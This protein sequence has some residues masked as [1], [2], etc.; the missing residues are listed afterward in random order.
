[1]LLLRACA[2]VSFSFLKGVG[3]DVELAEIT[4][5]QGELEQ[6]KV[7]RVFWIETISLVI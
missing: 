1:L 2:R 5:L 4:R 3:M 6:L 7:T